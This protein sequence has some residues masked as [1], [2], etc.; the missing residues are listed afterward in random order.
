MGNDSKTAGKIKEKIAKFSQ[1]ISQ[2]FKKPC[3]KFIRQIVFGIQAAK[4]V[5]LS[6]ISRTLNETIPL[7][8]TENRLSR[9]LS[10]YDFSGEIEKSILRKAGN[11]IGKETVLALDLSDIRK[12]FAR[13]MEH[14]AIVYDGSTGNIHSP[15]Y[16]LC[17][18][19]GAEVK[20]EELV[21][22]YQELFSQKAEGFISENQRIID[23]VGKVGRAVSN[24]GIWAIDRGGD[25]E[26][27]LRYFLDEKLNFVIRLASLRNIYY[28]GELKNVLTVARRCHLT[29][30][31]EVAFNRYG[32]EEKL[33]VKVGCRTIKLPFFAERGLTL[34]VIKGFGQ[35]PMMLLTTLT[36]KTP[37]EILETYLTRWK[38][39]ESFR[40]MKQTYHLEDVRVR[41]YQGLRNLACLVLAVFYFVSI[42]LG[43]KLKLHVLL[44]KIY[45]KAKRFFGIPAFKH[46]AIAD[47]IYACLISSLKGIDD[48]V[49]SIQKPELT[50]PLPLSLPT[51]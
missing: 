35:E 23:A 39:E 50:I 32:Q 45:A 28:Q 34:V 25:R 27:L 16:W 15:G 43:K 38:C 2:D 36:G 1:E 31:I 14:L 7:I 6:S 51:G 4:D 9:H 42:E 29:E 5:K 24:R 49:A 13:K 10:K 44:H 20:G 46:Y 47:G 30:E 41:S 48:L 19:F 22:L 37:E 11:R 17:S 18:V 21:P 33:K 26:E 40:F 12:E 8:K 3:Q